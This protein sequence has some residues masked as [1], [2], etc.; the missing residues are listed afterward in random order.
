VIAWRNS[1][2]FRLCVLSTFTINLAEEK[3]HA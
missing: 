2:F 3:K 1:C